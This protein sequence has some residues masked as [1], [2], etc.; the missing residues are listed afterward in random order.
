[1]NNTSPVIELHREMDASFT[2]MKGW[3]IA[4]SY[5]DICK[6]SSGVRDGLG[7][8]DITHRGKLRLS[9]KDHL[10]FL[11]GMLTNDV[12][13]LEESSGTYA[14]LLTVKGKIIT[15]MHVYK[16]SDH[17]HIDLEPGQNQRIKEH[18][19]R[20]RLTYRVDI[21]DRTHEYSLFHICGPR[22]KDYFRDIGLKEVSDLG[23][24]SFLE[25]S[26]SGINL[27]IFATDRTGETGYDLLVNNNSAI[28]L[29]KSMIDEG[30]NYNIVPFGSETLET[31]RIEAGI[32][33]LGKDFD[34][35]TIPIE[36]GLWNALNFE[37]GCYV[38]QE[39]IA[40]I[41]WRGRVNWHLA[42]IEIDYDKVPLENDIIYK[43]DKKVGRVTS[44]VYSH[45]LGKPICLAFLRREHKDP[46]TEV[47]IISG[48]QELQGTVTNI[49]FISKK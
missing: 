34:E 40:R 37:K 23:E 12:V 14:T 10:R 43:N 16:S 26:F 11:Q 41:K 46:G 4:R 3:T 13:K 2:D 48:N 21:E 6:E 35:S 17:V 36:A 49:P 27:T 8:C 47:L 22:V 33:V 19:E 31:L 7:I 30:L 44:S 1:M 20:F 39:V 15:D 9:G 32:P 29:W 18:L 5:R 38:G 42:G 28:E 25:T 45:I 24:L